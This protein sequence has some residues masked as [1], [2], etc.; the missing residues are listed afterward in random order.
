MTNETT[1]AGNIDSLRERFRGELILPD[2]PAYDDDRRL[3]NLVHDKYP[4]VIARCAGTAD[5]VEAVRFAR[6]AG[7]EIAVR[8]GGRHMAGF[9]STDDGLVIDLSAMRAVK[10]DQQEQTAWVQTGCNGGDVQAG[11]LVFGLGAVTG[12]TST[13]GIGG[14]NLHGGIGWLTPSMG[15]G[16][17]TI[18]ELELVTADGKVLRVAPDEDPELFWA[19][20]GAASNFGVVTWMKLQ[21]QPVPEK[22]LAGS[23]IYRAERIPDVLRFLREFCASEQ[24]DA[25]LPMLDFVRAPDDEWLPEALHG[26]LV[27]SVTVVYPGELARAEEALRPLT[28]GHPPDAGELAPQGLLDFMRELDAEYPPMRQWYD[29]EQVADLSDDV[30][31]VI[32]DQARR[33]AENELGE[34]SSLIMYPFTGAAAR[35][36]KVANSFPHGRLGGWSITTGLFWEEEADDARHEAWSNEL[37]DAIREAGV[38]TGVVYGNIQQV[39]D[40]Q[41]QLRSYGEEAWQR[42]TKV[43]AKYDPDNVFHR[44]HNI[45]P[46]E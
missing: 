13:T 28:E 30:I 4:A 37:F 18:L 42:L 7:L 21:L 25:V 9:A 1:A 33:F 10:V 27:L 29:E 44:N 11:T 17:D 6:A 3:F 35:E 20:R 39:P 43:K 8:S 22:M 5:V 23:L 40:Q 26:E 15:W 16:V 34:K 45:P 41:R 19:V 32:V 24:S 14:V 2:D 31:D 12:A 46:S 38:A 36:P